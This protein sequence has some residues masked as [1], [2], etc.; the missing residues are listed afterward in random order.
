MNLAGCAGVTALALLQGGL[1]ALPRADALE[2]LSRVRSPAWAALL[3]GSI[4]LGTFGPLALPS[5]ASAIVLAGAIA[6]PLLA[7]V[8]VIAVARGP[9]FALLVIALVLALAAAL[10]SGWERQLSATLLTALGSLALGCAVARLIPP[11]WVV[12]GVLVMAAADMVLLA[13]GVGH[14]A[15]ALLADADANAHGPVFDRAAIGPITVDYPDL[16]LAAMLGGFL[17]RRDQ[18]WAAAGLVFVLAA[19]FGL[20]LPIQSELPATVPLALA[21]LA[22][23]CMR[24]ARR[25]RTLALP[26][27]AGAA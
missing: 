20:L 10:I 11:R 18:Q 23:E 4:L 15:G 12:I 13:S 27:P 7:A 8:A 9:R 5:M 1:V 16:V 22:V 6:T 21:L 19:C 24:F 3:P 2:V 25:R 14:T 26:A 17:A